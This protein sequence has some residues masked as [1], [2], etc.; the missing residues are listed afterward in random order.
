[1]EIIG[2][3][4]DYYNL[5]LI[6]VLVFSVCLQIFFLGYIY[7]RIPFFVRKVSKNQVFNNCDVPP[8]VSVVVC[9][10]NN[11][12][13]LEQLLPE[14][15]GQNYP[16]FEVVVVD[17]CSEDSTEDVLSD[18]RSR[19]PDLR[20]TY[21]KNEA[22]F[23]DPKQFAR[24]VGVK[25]ARF[26]WVLFMDPVARPDTKNWLAAMSLSFTSQRSFVLGYFS[27]QYK[28]G[29]ANAFIRYDSLCSF[30]NY[31]GCAL[32]L[33]P[34]SGDI[35]NM[36]VRKSLFHHEEAFRKYANVHSGNVPLFMNGLASRAN[37]AVCVHPDAR[38]LSP[39][40]DSFLA[41]FAARRNV[42]YLSGSN[43]STGRMMKVL[44]PVSRF[45][46]FVSFVLSMFTVWWPYVLGIYAFRTVLSWTVFGYTQRCFGEKK[47]FG[48]IVFFDGLMPF[49]YLYIVISN[50]FTNRPVRYY[51]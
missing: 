14:L 48:L 45:L 20:T 39:H 2:L 9:A 44:E 50:L 23:L 6:S 26:E 22:W 3:Y 32:S 8:P 17:N 33:S 24:F 36:A 10:R 12:E 4:F 21:I 1:M 11:A 7:F 5:L 38:V 37:T 49:F 16:S 29:L 18:M 15:F 42:S 51:L 30:M 41:W 46:F 13:D 31:F 28:P 47:L 27:Y 34:F 25:A 19:Y 35:R 40:P 43:K